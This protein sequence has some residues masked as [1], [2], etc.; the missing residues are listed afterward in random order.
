MILGVGEHSARAPLDAPI[1]QA[2]I[3]AAE[4]LYSQA[5]VIYPTM[6]GSGPMYPLSEALGIPAVLAGINYPRS[7]VHAPNENIRLADYLEGIKYMGE[8]IRRF[9]AVE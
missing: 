1:V 9:G 2:A 5:P 3:A 8:L 6:A 4:A 7:K